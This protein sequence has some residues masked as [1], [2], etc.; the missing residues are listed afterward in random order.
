[1]GVIRL[2][3]SCRTSTAVLPSP[4]RTIGPKEGSQ[5]SLTISS[6]QPQAQRPL[7]RAHPQR[8]AVGRRFGNRCRGR[9]DRLRVFKLHVHV[10]IVRPFAPVQDRQQGDIH[11]DETADPLCCLDRFRRRLNAFAVWN[12]QST[13][14]GKLLRLGFSQGR[15]DRPDRRRHRA[16]G[17]CID[18]TDLPGRR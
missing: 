3:V 8:F 2:V 10:D 16:Q 11:D 1:M 7:R 14:N 17:F 18:L 9:P 12:R 15:S 6:V 5:V 4:G 13:F